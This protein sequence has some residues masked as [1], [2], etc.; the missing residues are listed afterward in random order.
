MHTIILAAGMSKR[1]YDE[2]YLVPKPLIRLSWRGKE[3]TML[4]HVIATIPLEFR[5]IV[6]AT[7]PKW[8]REIGHNERIHVHPVE[9]T[10]G[11]AE[12]AYKTLRALIPEATLILDVDVLNFTNDLLRLGSLNNTMGVLVGESANPAFSYVDQKDEFKHIYEKRRVSK[13]A[14]RGA[15]FISAIHINAFMSA[16]EKKMPLN[17]EPFISHI[18]NHVPIMKTALEVSYTPI[19]WGTPR[20]VRLSGAHITTPREGDNARNR[21]PEHQGRSA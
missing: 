6:I 15:Y 17:G 18:F 7:H 10:R 16:L 8:I 2:G 14:V 4:E 12:T 20:D 5:D 21:S 19:E 3:Q 1:F 9:A 11:P 13:Y